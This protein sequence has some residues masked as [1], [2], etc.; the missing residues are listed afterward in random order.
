MTNISMMSVSVD[1]F[2]AYHVS[3]L[4]VVRLAWGAGVVGPAT[5]SRI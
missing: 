3:K 1:C 2:I 5:R 4:G